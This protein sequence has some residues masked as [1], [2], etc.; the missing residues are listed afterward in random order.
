MQ[1][2]LQCQRRQH[3]QMWKMALF[4]N[5]ITQESENDRDSEDDMIQVTHVTS[6]LPIYIE[7]PHTFLY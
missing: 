1:P 7:Q 3:A 5:N 6:K 4:Y 2:L